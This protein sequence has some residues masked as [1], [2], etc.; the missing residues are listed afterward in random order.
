MCGVA[1]AQ[2]LRAVCASE[3]NWIELDCI[4]LNLIE[5]GLLGEHNK[6]NHIPNKQS[7]KAAYQF[8]LLDI[9]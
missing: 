1:Y 8:K 6:A 5:S 3:T 7:P 2:D 9:S 4:R